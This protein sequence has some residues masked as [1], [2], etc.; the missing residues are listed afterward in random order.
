MEIAQFSLIIETIKLLKKSTAL[1]GILVNLELTSSPRSAANQLD[2]SGF[3]FLLNVSY[4][5]MHRHRQTDKRTDRDKD[6]RTDRL[7]G[8]LADKVL[9]VLPLRS[10]DQFLEEK[11]GE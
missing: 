5:N 2:H 10:L 9:L 6:R 8:K 3:S 1:T 7:T 11:Y 4:C